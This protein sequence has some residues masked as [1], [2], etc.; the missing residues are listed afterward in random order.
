MVRALRREEKGLASD[1]FEVFATLTGLA[2]DVC[3][4]QNG[5]THGRYFH[6]FQTL[7][8]NKQDEKLN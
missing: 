4:A 7:I 1:V 5:G 8:F 6:H 3:W 2:R